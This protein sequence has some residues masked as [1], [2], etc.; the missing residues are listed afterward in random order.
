[1]KKFR[2]K[3]LEGL[4]QRYGSGELALGGTVAHLADQAEFEAFLGMLE[5]KAW[6]VY[7]KEPFAGPE[8]VLKYLTGYTHRVALSDRRLLRMSDTHVTLSYKDYASECA[9]KELELAGE[10]LVRRFSLH[11]LPKGFKRMRSY[12]LLA[13]RDLQARLTRCRVLLAGRR[14]QGDGG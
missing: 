3:F 2:R 7:A 4:R 8:A 12:G 5:E 11:L 6:V 9:S 1:M 14:N 13:H 10:E